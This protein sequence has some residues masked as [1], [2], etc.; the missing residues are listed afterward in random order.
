[1]KK[2]KLRVWV[3]V[4]ILVIVLLGVFKLTDNY[5]KKEVR[6]CIESGNSQSYCEYELYK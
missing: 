4:V 5:T 2:M 1:M 6:N 3:K